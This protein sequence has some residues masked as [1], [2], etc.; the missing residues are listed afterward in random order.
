MGIIGSFTFSGFSFLCPDDDGLLEEAAPDAAACDCLPWLL[1]PAAPAFLLL[2][3]PPCQDC[4][5]GDWGLVRGCDV[6]PK[7]ADADEVI[8]LSARGGNSGALC[9]L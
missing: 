7:F 2:P 8:G 5:M 4:E 3:L 6:G 9:T 1:A